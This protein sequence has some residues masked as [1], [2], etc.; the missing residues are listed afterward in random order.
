MTGYFIAL[1]HFSPD[2][3]DKILEMLLLIPVLLMLIKLFRTFFKLVKADPKGIIAAFG[4]VIGVILLLVI[5][6]MLMGGEMW[7]AILMLLFFGTLFVFY[8]VCDPKGMLKF[9]LLVFGFIA[10][11]VAAGFFFGV[12]AAAAVGINGVFAFI[13]LPSFLRL[14][15]CIKLEL[16]GIS[17]DGEVIGQNSGRDTSYIVGYTAS[18][19]V[20]YTEICDFFSLRKADSGSV[21]TVL[22]DKDAPEKVCVKKY[23]LIA[24]IFQYGI[25]LAIQAISLGLTIFINA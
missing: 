3:Y 18:N 4:V 19:G 20:Y 8:L 11:V 24:R 12:N 14:V 10:V 1:S 16:S 22:Y 6:G 15:R 7:S 13:A 2:V 23:T 5:P 9:V 21:Y 17:T 25:F